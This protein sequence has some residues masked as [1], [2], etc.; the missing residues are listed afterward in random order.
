MYHI[1]KILPEQELLCI[2][3]QMRSVVKLNPQKYIRVLLNGGKQGGLALHLTA[4]MRFRL[5]LHLNMQSANF[6]Y[7]RNVSALPK[8]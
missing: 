3:R 8:G 1:I 5:R 6:T 2:F 4:N 7:S